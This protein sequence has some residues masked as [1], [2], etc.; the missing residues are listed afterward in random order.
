MDSNLNHV[1]DVKRCKQSKEHLQSDKQTI[2]IAV[3]F[4]YN[5][6][7]PLKFH[8]R[9]SDRKRYDYST[10]AKFNFYLGYDIG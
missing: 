4:L 8:S 10:L 2:P 3:T 6:N 1:S 9:N 5:F 7:F